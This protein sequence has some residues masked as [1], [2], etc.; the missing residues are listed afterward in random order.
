MAVEVDLAIDVEIVMWYSQ[1]R[2][3]SGF[4]ESTSIRKSRDFLRAQVVYLKGKF[5]S[6]TEF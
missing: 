4:R 2:D 3:N 6:G 5:S 1:I